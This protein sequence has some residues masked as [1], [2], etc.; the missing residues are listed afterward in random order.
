MKVL[1][2]QTNDF[3]TQIKKLIWQ[4]QNFTSRKP[5]YIGYRGKPMD[6]W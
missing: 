2:L 6:P 3:Q 1:A 4:L 5:Y